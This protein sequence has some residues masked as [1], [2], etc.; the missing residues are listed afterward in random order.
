[1]KQKSLPEGNLRFN[2]IWENS[3][4]EMGV[5]SE[6][7]Y[8]L[9]EEEVKGDQKKKKKPGKVREILG[10]GRGSLSN[11]QGRDMLRSQGSLRKSPECR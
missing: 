10:S 8:G 6:F 9:K 3:G 11:V 5:E 4:I 1:M 2:W 7:L